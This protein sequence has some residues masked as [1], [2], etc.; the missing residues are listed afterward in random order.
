MSPGLGRS[1]RV[2]PGVAREEKRWAWDMHKVV[3][4]RRQTENFGFYIRG[5]KEYGFG[6][7]VSGLDRGGH[8]QRQVRT[9]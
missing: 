9:M 7:F 4:I 5:G 8:A 6:I 3:L 2:S 1:G